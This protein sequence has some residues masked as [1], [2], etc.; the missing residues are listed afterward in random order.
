MGLLNPRRVGGLGA[1][2]AR[3]NM[4]SSYSQ[5]LFANQALID[6]I[7][8]EKGGAGWGGGLKRAAWRMEGGSGNSVSSGFIGELTA[9]ILDYLVSK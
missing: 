9:S 4:R 7:N 5:L 2:G 8:D 1:V 3:I 6:R